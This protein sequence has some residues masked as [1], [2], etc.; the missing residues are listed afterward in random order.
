VTGTSFGFPVLGRGDGQTSPL[1][2]LA[3]SGEVFPSC[4]LGVWEG[5][6]LAGLLWQSPRTIALVTPE[7]R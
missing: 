7:T 1:S 6:P 2:F 5:F 4:G 3:L